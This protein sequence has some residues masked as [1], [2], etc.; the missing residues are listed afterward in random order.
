METEA[1]HGYNAICSLRREVA[2]MAEAVLKQLQHEIEQLG[3][4]QR[5]QLLEVARAFAT[6]G[7]RG[8]A[9]RRL[10]RFAGSIPSDDL[11][12]MASEIESGCGQ[13]NA[14]EW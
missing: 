4:R 13:V 14:D 2:N 6:I 7:R 8:T 12:I 5:R 10:A 3:P 9:G 11:Q 1:S